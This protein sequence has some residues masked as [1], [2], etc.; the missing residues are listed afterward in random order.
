MIQ[1]SKNSIRVVLLVTAAVLVGVFIGRHY[2]LGQTSSFQ[3]GLF[4]QSGSK[5]DQV[6]RMVGK[7]YV[8]TLDTD[9]LTEMA[10]V[11]LLAQLDPHSV[12]M[13][14]VDYSSF[15]S[16]MEGKFDGIGVEFNIVRDTVVVVHVLSGGPASKVGMQ[17]GDRIVD[18]EGESIAGIGIKNSDV[19]SKL[20]GEKGSKVAL[21]V[22]RPRLKK[23]IDFVLT[24]GAI[25]VYSVENA[26]MLNKETGIIQVSRFIENTHRDFAKALKDLKK[27]GM[28]NLIVDLRGNGGGYLN[29]ATKMADEFL[30][31][32]VITYTQGAHRKRTDYM[33]N[34]GGLF[35][36]GKLVVL[37][38]ESSASAS[39][40]LAGAIQ[41]HDRG[42]I[43]GRTSFGKGLVQEVLKLPDASAIRLTIA[44]YYTPSGRSIQRPYSMD[45]WSYYQ[46]GLSGVHSDS[47]PTKSES[48]FTKGGREVFEAGGIQ[49]DHKVET[50]TSE[51]T[52]AIF[53]LWQTGILYEVAF[54][55]AD[56][57]RNVEKIPT[58]LD[59]QILA[60]IAQKQGEAQKYNASEK[61]FIILQTKRLMAR[62]LDHKS[63][64]TKYILQSDKDIQEALKALENYNLNY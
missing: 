35:E 52:D 34:R 16:E 48:F 64:I 57:N 28:Q 31:S 51:I 12:Y 4:M 60:A 50:D 49:P 40:V 58:D 59:A 19:V 1:N 18:V 2:R 6:L 25:P 46:Q 17:D 63:G 15:N 61:Q 33:A 11:N 44:R 39:E 13:P 3:K 53:G 42:L 29:E 62:N 27:M 47:V 56:N 43:V 41:D 22:Y 24:R 45:K 55:L 26:I 37:I 21:R 10:I 32:G 7:E 20:R 14:P 8:D 5:I 36:K 9:S 30:D 54:D 38:D 23:E